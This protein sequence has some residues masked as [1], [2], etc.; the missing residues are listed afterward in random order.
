MLCIPGVWNFSSKLFERDFSRDDS[1]IADWS[2]NDFRFLRLKLRITS[3][4]DFYSY[5]DIA[6]KLDYN[7]TAE[8]V[9]KKI[10]RDGKFKFYR[11]RY[12]HNL[13]E[14]KKKLR[15]EMAK[16]IAQAGFKLY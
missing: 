5:Q 11:A 12:Q 16:K 9:R 3:E 2:V 1:S 4:S 10:S 6:D 14:R 7:T 8:A 13:D 15:V